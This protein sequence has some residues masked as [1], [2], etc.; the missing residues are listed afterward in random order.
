M[1]VQNGMTVAHPDPAG[2][3]TSVAFLAA[4]ALAGTN[5]RLVEYSFREFMCQPITNWADGTSP[6]D[7]I[8]RDVDRMPGGS[9]NK[10]LTTCKNCHANMD[11]MRG[12]FGLVDY[13]ANNGIPTFGTTIVAK[14]LRNADVYPAGFKMTD[15]SFINYTN[16][17]NNA[18]QFGW[19]SAQ[20][21]GTGIKQFATMLSKSKGFSRCLVRRVFTD[22]CKRAPAA[23]EETMVRSVADQFET[24][25]YH[26]RN[27]FETV[28][29]RPE[30]GVNN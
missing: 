3:L 6:D 21:T 2:I 23:T 5:R 1:I 7:H 17:G 28:A 24:S 11:G 30:C 25:N 13:D 8:G 20:M 27:L 18:D 16:V 9:P 15:T 29:L 14:M 10:F 26:L 19:G 22:V 12:A 4:H